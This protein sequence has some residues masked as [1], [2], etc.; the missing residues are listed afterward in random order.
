MEEFYM[1]SCQPLN[2][3]SLRTGKGC[4]FGYETA[5]ICHA[6]RTNSLEKHSVV[7]SDSKVLLSCGGSFTFVLIYDNK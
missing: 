3:Q 4:I 5:P 6:A 7:G 2:V 1:F